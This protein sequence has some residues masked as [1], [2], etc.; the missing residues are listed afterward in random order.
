MV[1]A[2]LTEPE[3]A[4]NRDP[5]LEAIALW[6]PVQAQLGRDLESASI[7]DFP[8]IVDRHKNAPGN[9]YLDFEAIVNEAGYAFLRRGATEK[10]IALFQLNT[11]NYPDS[12]NAFDSLG[13][14]YLAAGKKELAIESYNKALAIRPDF[15][16]SQEA[17]KKLQ[18]Q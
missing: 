14:A 10:A 11:N 3:F 7:S 8:A 18:S 17:L 15:R 6:V 9:R 5:A 2:D 12:A 1:A 16:S 4:Q 13:E